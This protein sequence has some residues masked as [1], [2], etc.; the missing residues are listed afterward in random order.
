METAVVIVAAGRGTRA[1]GRDIPKQYRPLA[2][3]PVLTRAMDAF[4]ESLGASSIVTVIHPDDRDHYNGAVAPFSDQLRDPVMGGATRQL[5]VGAGLESLAEVAP[6]HVL[7]HDAAR[8]SYHAG[9][10]FA[11]LRR[12]RDASLSC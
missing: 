8:S 3:T 5:S 1:G 4:V 7:I 9:D 11:R 6:R 10:D 2:G 12:A